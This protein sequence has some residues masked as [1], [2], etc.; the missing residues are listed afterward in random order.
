VCEMADHPN[1]L[2]VTATPEGGETYAEVA[3]EA[4]FRRWNKVREWIA[5]EREFLAWR[6]G[7]E[8]ARRAWQATHDKSK[9]DALLMGAALTQ[10]QSWFAQRAED[11]PKVDREFIALS[12]ERERKRQARARRAQALIYVL[13]VGIIGSLV[14]IIEKEEIKEQINWFTVLRPYRVAN[15]DPYVLKPEAE[16]AFKALASFRECG[17]DCPEMIVIPAGS[18]MMGSPTTEQGG[19]SNEAPQH[20]VV[21]AERFAVSKFDVTFA[22]WDACV[23]VGGCPKA[24][25]SN[26]GRDTRPVINIG[27]DDAQTYVAWLS[28]M[29]GKDYRLLTEAEWEYAARAGTTTAYYWGGEIGK[30]NAK[31]CGSEWDSRQTSPVGSFKPNAFGL[32]DMAGNM[33]QWAQD[34]YHGDYKEAPTDG[35]AWTSGDCSNRVVRGGSW[36]SD[37]QVLRTANRRGAAAGGRDDDLGFRVGRTLVTP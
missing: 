19:N 13:L 16:R 24:G 34:C 28:K 15:F 17:K 20:K 12:I 31:G 11:L 32:Y 36:S 18:F 21:I 7:L 25:D 1:R 9:Q 29:T 37:P 2:L 22:D 27:W 10:A 4:I 6:S 23:S 26:F 14:G 3:H 35:S 33:W 5:A 8:T 30:G